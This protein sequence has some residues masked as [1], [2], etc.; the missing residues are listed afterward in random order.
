MKFHRLMKRLSEANLFLQPDK[1]LKREV[2]YLG[3]IITENGVRS[4]PKKIIAVKN[5][6]TPKTR[7]NIKQFLGFAGYYRRFIENFSK[8][9]KLLSDLTKQSVTFEWK[10][11]QQEAFDKLRNILCAEPIL[12]YPNFNEPFVITTDASGYAIRAIL[13]Q[14]KIGS[15][16]PIAP[17]HQEF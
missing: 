17:M 7:K 14:G 16:L 5:F 8:I 10:Q 1:F 6:P 15:D 9:A 12:Q 3:H 2:I 4:D 11:E 13:S